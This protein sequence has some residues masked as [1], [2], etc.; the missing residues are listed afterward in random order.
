MVP[1]NRTKH[2]VKM[3]APPLAHVSQSE[4]VLPGRRHL[5]MEE[6]RRPGPNKSCRLTFLVSVSTR[7]TS[8]SLPKPP[9]ILTFHE[10]NGRCQ[11]SAA[12]SGSVG[13]FYERR[14]K[15]THGRFNQARAAWLLYPTVQQ[16][17]FYSSEVASRVTDPE[18][19]R[20]V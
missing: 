19:C 13:N 15:V 14:A 16:Q 9:P 8:D 12:T 10:I 18:R 6:Q 1:R 4:P 20:R 11:M 2:V 3:V 5:F 17:P 7:P